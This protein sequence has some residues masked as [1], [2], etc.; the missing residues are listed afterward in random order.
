MSNTKTVGMVDMK[1]GSYIVIDD[2]ACKVVDV[3]VSKSG[4]HGHAKH[5]LTAVGILDGKKRVIVQPA[6]DNVETPMIEKKNAQ[7]LSIA[8]DKA[9]VMDS[10][11]YETFELV[12]PDD[13]KEHVKE[14]ITIMY[15]IV[16]N[17]R[18]MKQV[19]G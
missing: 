11:S 1:E 19:V 13:M 5:R 4:K 8:G 15:W 16:L 17:D 6:H 18:V 2:V 7:V 12:I 10:L 9:T 14:G 3:Q